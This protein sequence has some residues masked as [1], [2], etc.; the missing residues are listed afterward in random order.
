MRL[1]V[2]DVA[3]WIETGLSTDFEFAVRTAEHGHLSDRLAPYVARIGRRPGPEALRGGSWWLAARV[4]RSFM[5]VSANTRCPKNCLRRGK[6]RTRLGRGR[7]S[8]S[9][10]LSDDTYA[11]PDQDLRERSACHGR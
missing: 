8:I 5:S 10:F 3:A 9:G 11:H 6:A 2:R 4:Q 7:P 1:V